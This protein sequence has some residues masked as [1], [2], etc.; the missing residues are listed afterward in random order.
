MFLICSWGGGEWEIYTGRGELNLPGEISSWDGGFL[1]VGFGPTLLKC[2]CTIRYKVHY[3]V[4]A[5][6]LRYKEFKI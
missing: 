6:Y 4:Y 3:I 5:A 2:T 1:P